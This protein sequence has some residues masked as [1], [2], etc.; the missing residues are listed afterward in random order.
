MDRRGADPYHAEDMVETRTAGS[1][2]PAEPAATDTEPRFPVEVEGFSGTLEQL[3]VRAQR[4]EVDLDGIAVAEITA[5]FR[6]RMDDAGDQV[7]LREMAD[8]LSL[9]ARLIALKAARLH[10]AESAAVEDEEEDPGGDAGRRL[11]EYRLFKAA[12][13]AL[14]AEAAE[15]GARSFLSL[16]APDVIPLERLR[17]P[18]ERLAAA[19]RDVLV[20]LSEAEPLPI[21]AMTFSVDDKM[22]ELRV[23]LRGGELA[24]EELFAT[25]TTRLEA[26]ACFLALLE[27]LRLGEAVVEQEEP[28]GPISVRAGG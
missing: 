16:V 3:V 12:A 13:E 8:F 22:D 21:G 17:I 10:P 23:R 27:L 2:A 14:L 9:A 28:F 1:I 11:S 26:V 7:D 4:G 24:F 20:R 18:P 25:V 5:R 19:F 15:E 6:A